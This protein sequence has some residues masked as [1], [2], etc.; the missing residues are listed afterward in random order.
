MAM[1]RQDRTKLEVKDISPMDTSGGQAE[2]AAQ[3]NVV[4]IVVEARIL[5]LVSLA[6]HHLIKSVKTARAFRHDLR[7]D[8]RF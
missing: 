7:I 3:D 5:T 8:D 4:A 6:D 2:D 1:L